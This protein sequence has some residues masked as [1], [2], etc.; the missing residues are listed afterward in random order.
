MPTSRAGGSAGRLLSS[1]PWMYDGPLTPLKAI[2]NQNPMQ[3]N[4]PLIEFEAGSRAASPSIASS[5]SQEE[6]LAA[7]EANIEQSYLRKVSTS[8]SFL[9]VKQQK[10][11]LWHDALLMKK[12]VAEKLLQA[13][14]II[15][16]IEDEIAEH[17]TRET[18]VRLR[19]RYYK[20]DD[21]STPDGQFISA[22]S[23][24]LVK[25]SPRVPV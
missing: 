6:H 4:K 3:F 16:E 20:I 8:Q 10:S 7:F 2:P 17:L 9:S 18:I 12:D 25:P 13:Q 5:T 23:A 21:K 22:V 24:V 14:K 1:F 11:R 15:Q 19:S